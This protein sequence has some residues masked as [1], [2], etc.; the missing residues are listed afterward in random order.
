M[1]LPHLAPAVIVLAPAPEEFREARSISALRLSF[2]GAASDGDYLV[3]Q[4]R[5]PVV[6]IAGAT[7]ATPAA[8]LIPLDQNFPARAH[9]AVRLWR[10][11]TARAVDRSADDLTTS[12]RR[13]LALVLRA[14]DAHLAGEAYRAIAQGLFGERRVPSGSAWKTHDL[15]DRTIRLVRTG[16]HLMHGGYLELLGHHRRR[17]R[18]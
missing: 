6:L 5:T 2:Q 12:R 15:R 8:A 13:R 17:R 14:L 11:V 4:D 1:W 16:L 7:T 9:A 3:L 18:Q 10:A